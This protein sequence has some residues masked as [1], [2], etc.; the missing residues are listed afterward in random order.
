MV[1]RCNGC[2]GCVAV[3][4]DVP[5]TVFVTIQS[6]GGVWS[7]ARGGVLVVT[8]VG[9]LEAH[10]ESYRYCGVVPG[11]Q[12]PRFSGVAS[13]GGGGAA[14]LQVPSSLRRPPTSIV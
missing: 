2:L 5:C 6:R 9:V 10:A 3:L 14:R 11:L 13:A 1:R 12:E 8:V 4:C 7:A